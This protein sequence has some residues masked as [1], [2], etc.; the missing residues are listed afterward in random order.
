VS[1]KTTP[2]KDALFQDLLKTPTPGSRHR[3][4]LTPRRGAENADLLMTPSRI[5]P[6]RKM[7][8]PRGT[9]AATIAPETPFT[10]QLNA[11]LSGDNF[12]SPSQGIDF[13]AFPTFNTPGRVQFGEF[14]HDDFMSSDMPMPSSPPKNGALGLGFEL[15]EDPTTSTSGLWGGASMFES[16]PMLGSFD[17]DI[18]MEMNEMSESS[19]LLKMHVG[20][21]TVDFAAMIEEVVAHNTADSHDQDSTST[22]SPETQSSNIGK[23]PEVPVSE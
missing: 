22:H 4:P 5:T 13:S 9:R 3:N 8:T 19:A 16:D 21:V 17:N 6:S 12:P 20:G 11:M 1:P 14:M 18:K 7:L 2:Q 15:Y 10:R 23:T